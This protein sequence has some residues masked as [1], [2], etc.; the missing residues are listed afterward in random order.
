MTAAE[1]VINTVM[2]FRL[3]AVVETY[4]SRTYK[5][6]SAIRREERELKRFLALCVLYPDEQFPMFTF[7]DDFWHEFICHT[8]LYHEFCEQWAGGYIHH[9]PF[10]S[11]TRPGS[12]QP[13]HTIRRLYRRHFGYVPRY[14]R[15][16]SDCHGQ[17]GCSS[18]R[19]ACSSGY[20]G[21]SRTLAA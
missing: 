8:K 19:T 18:C 5:S 16:S 4:E 2:A 7:A 10:T 3:D 15:G 20:D 1:Y 21:D 17:S 13:F 14:M 6:R 11:D 9:E 12:E